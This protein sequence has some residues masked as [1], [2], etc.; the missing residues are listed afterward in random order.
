M[1]VRSTDTR[2]R[3]LDVDV[4]L[5]PSLGSVGDLLEVVRFTVGLV[6]GTEALEG[7]GNNRS[8]HIQLK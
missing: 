8:R 7:G 2:V 5:I 6:T 4:E 1:K 3:D